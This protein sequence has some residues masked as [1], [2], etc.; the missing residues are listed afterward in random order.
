[1]DVE[2]MACGFLWLLASLQSIYDKF[3]VKWYSNLE[4]ESGQRNLA[5]TML[6]IDEQMWLLV[7]SER[8]V[9]YV[10]FVFNLWFTLQLPTMKVFMMLKDEHLKASVN[11]LHKRLRK[12][13]GNVSF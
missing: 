7:A 12:N 4:N 6:A 5:P 13:K 9:T 8:R 11:D 10:S 3:L 1:M 2:N